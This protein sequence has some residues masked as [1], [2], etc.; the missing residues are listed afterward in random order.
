MSLAIPPLISSQAGQITFYLNEWASQNG[1]IAVT[2]SN[3]R[4]MWSQATQ[5]SD[6]PTIYTCYMGE[7]AR[8]GDFSR[9]V[10]RVDRSWATLVKRG[11]GFNANRGDSLT[12]TVGNAIPFYD[13]V[14]IIR[15]KIRA[16][17]SISEEDLVEFSSI[18]PW[19]LGNQILDAYLIEY[20]TANDLPTITSVPQDQTN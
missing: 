19:Q 18:R 15:D 4:D 2:T 13:V 6:R 5:A 7:T 11:R 20:K 14:E 9:W 16:I 8:G 12:Q 10:H 3:L 17:L 1:G